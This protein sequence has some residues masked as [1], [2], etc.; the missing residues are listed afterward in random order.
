MKPPELRRLTNDDIPDL[1]KAEGKDRLFSTLNFFMEQVTN[2]LTAKLTI[3]DNVTGQVLTAK[4]TTPTTYEVSSDFTP[5][6][7]AV[8]TQPLAVIVGKIVKTNE[9]TLVLKSAVTV[10]WTQVTSTQLRVN[11]VTGL[12]DNT[13][14]TITLVV[15]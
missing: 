12:E 10:D 13:N 8:K 4:F 11:F 15:L 6:Q 14:Y 5:F 7:L 2:I 1:S 3:G 9:Q